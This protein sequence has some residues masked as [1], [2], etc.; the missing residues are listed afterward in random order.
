MIRLQG[1]GVFLTFCWQDCRRTL[2]WSAYMIRVQV[3]SVS[4][5]FFRWQHCRAL[6]QRTRCHHPMLTHP[7]SPL[8]TQPPLKPTCPTSWPQHRIQANARRLRPCPPTRKREEGMPSTTPSGPTSACSAARSSC[9][10]RS[11]TGTWWCAG[12]TAPSSARCAPKGS[13]SRRTWTRTWSS[14]SGSSA[15]AVTSAARRT[16]WRGTWFGTW[17]HA[18]TC[19]PC[20]TKACRRTFRSGNR[21]QF[22]KTRPVRSTVVQMPRSAVCCSGAEMS[23]LCVAQLCRCPGL[24]FAAVVLKCQDSS[25]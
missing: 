10:S 19:W 14:T 1:F 2:A 11:L 4:F 24:L 25:A 7:L 5:F 6:Q 16:W 3:F 18:C 23:R 15:T 22:P 17:R 8:T 12:A 13:T 9:T 21:I 20:T